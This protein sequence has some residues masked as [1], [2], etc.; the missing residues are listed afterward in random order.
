MKPWENF[1]FKSRSREVLYIIQNLKRQKKRLINL[2]TKKI[3]FSA[4]NH[5]EQNPRKTLNLR[6]NTTHNIGKGKI[7]L[8]CEEPP[9]I[10]F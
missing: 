10:I 5:H 6:G 8:I 1:F 9:Q 2:T 3:F 7:S 4:K